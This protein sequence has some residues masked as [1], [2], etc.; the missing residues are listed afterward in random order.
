MK[1]APREFKCQL[2]SRLASTKAG[3]RGGVAQSA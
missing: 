3:H 2:G 1:G